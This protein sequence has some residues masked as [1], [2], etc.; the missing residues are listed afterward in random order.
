MIAPSK[1]LFATAGIPLS[2]T[3]RDTANG[4]KRVKE[5]GLGAMELEFVQSVFISKEKAPDVKKVAQEQEV[6]LTCHAPY[7]IN[8]NAIEPQK[9]GASR[10]RILQ[11]A[12][13]LD[14]CGG[15]SVCFHPGYY[16][17]IEPSKVYESVK[18]ELKKV[19]EEVKTLGLKV[20]IRPETTGK[21]NQFGTIEELCELSAEF[22]N[23]LPVVDFS[24]LH[25]RTNG[26]FNT[27]EE[28]EYVLGL[29]EKKLGKVAISN[30]HMHLSGIAYN[31]TGERN[32]LILKE[33]DMNYIAVLQTLK[34]FGAKGVLVC[35]SPNIEEDALLLKRTY[36]G[37]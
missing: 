15:Y 28:F 6:V 23:V 19:L 10:S 33:S 25:A 3:P 8:L 12:K 4:I 7:F 29:I 35:E 22:D 5:L 27:K 24:H 2:T 37:L 26:K 21:P 16:L 20:W 1:L 9:R 13:I 17:K 14:A 36:E 32:H 18:S 11:S 30:M 31:A 34:D